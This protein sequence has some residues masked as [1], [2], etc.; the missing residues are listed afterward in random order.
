MPKLCEVVEWTKTKMYC[1]GTIC[2]RC[3]LAALLIVKLGLTEVG[4]QAKPLKYSR[5]KVVFCTNLGQTLKRTA[6]DFD[7]QLT[8]AQQRLTYAL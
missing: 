4:N 3:I 5:N 6:T 7:I 2:Q 8:V 1:Q